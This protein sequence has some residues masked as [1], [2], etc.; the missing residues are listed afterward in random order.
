MNIAD[1]TIAVSFHE[2]AFQPLQAWRKFNC[3]NY[4]DN[5]TIAFV[6]IDVFNPT[7]EELISSNKL[8]ESFYMMSEDN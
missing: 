7:S 4:K 5:A 6:K 1:A 8:I 2:S 3:K